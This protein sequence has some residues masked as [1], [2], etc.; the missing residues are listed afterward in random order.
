MRMQLAL[1]V[2]AQTASVALTLAT[3]LFVARVGGAEAQGSLA[4]VKSVIDLQVAVCSLGLPAGIV[5]M[6]NKAGTGHRPLFRL[7]I[8]YG[9][10]LLLALSVFN[11]GLLI[12]IRPTLEGGRIALMAVLLGTAAALS[13]AYALQRGIVLV[14]SDGVIFSLLSVMPAIAIAAGVVVFLNQTPL[15]MEKAYAVSGLLC[16]IASSMYLRRSL[17]TFPQGGPSDIHWPMLRGQSSQM[18]FQAVFLGLQFFLS[19]AWLEKVDSTLTMAGLFAIASMAVTLPN[20]LVSMVAPI[21]Y[22]RWS[23]TLD[24]AGYIVVRRRALALATGAQALSF[25]GIFLAPPVIPL[26]FG[27]PFAAAIPAVCILLCTPFAV[28]AGRILTP[29]LQGMGNAKQVTWS[30]AIRLF[31]IVSTVP[32]LRAV[33]L[34]PLI[35]ISSS[36]LVGEYGA[37]FVLIV[38]SKSFS[39]V[40]S[41]RRFRA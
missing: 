23:K 12:V 9:A 13:T 28:I 27:P 24:M 35:A 37:L 36:W 29:A 34:D 26:V 19:N 20:Q 41:P 25:L 30:C 18:F 6:L 33:G 39:A 10:L 8:G 3:S 11:I 5:F 1:T 4:L 38:H 22:N 21:L 31:L 15:P 32:I 40:F 7:S 16:F 14:R 17:R 2:I